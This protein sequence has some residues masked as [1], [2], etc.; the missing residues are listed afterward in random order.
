[1]IGQIVRLLCIGKRPI[2]LSVRSSQ[3]RTHEQHKFDCTGCAVVFER[4]G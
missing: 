1:M 4:D 2:L 3:V